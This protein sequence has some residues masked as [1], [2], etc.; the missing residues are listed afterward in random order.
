[1]IKIKFKFELRSK[2]AI[3][4]WK[5]NGDSLVYWFKMVQAQQFLHKYCILTKKQQLMTF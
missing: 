3:N 5:A 1:M 4:K 2:I